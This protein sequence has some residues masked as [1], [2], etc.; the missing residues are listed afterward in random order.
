MPLQQWIAYVRHPEPGSRG[1]CR[2]SK[3]RLAGAQNSCPPVAHLPTACPELA[4][5][6]RKRVDGSGA[7]FREYGV[8]WV[9]PEGGRIAEL[10][11]LVDS[12]DHAG[13]FAANRP[14][15]PGAGHPGASSRPRLEHRHHLRANARGLALLGRRRGPLQRTHRRLD[16]R[17]VARAHA[18][19]GGR[20]GAL[21]RTRAAS[22]LVRPG[23]T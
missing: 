10:R 5:V 12:D 21:G 19:A 6:G 20:Y 2:D 23:A 22:S 14:E 4:G 9:R 1:K 8:A 7:I 16:N 15:R 11:V 18:A 17:D 3:Q 13:C